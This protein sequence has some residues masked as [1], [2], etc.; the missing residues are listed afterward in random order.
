MINKLSQ[1]I[2]TYGLTNSIRSLVPFIILPILTAYLT[3]EEFG[4]L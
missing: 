1:D 4:Y 2:V 3:T